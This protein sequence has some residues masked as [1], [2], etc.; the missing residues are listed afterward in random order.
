M[1]TFTANRLTLVELA[2]RTK[3]GNVTAIAEVMNQ[4]NSVL[5]DAVWGA[6]NGL[7]SHMTTKRI[8]LP[9]GSWRKINQGVAREASKTVQVS[10]VIGMLEAFSQADEVLVDISPNPGE[11]RWTEDVAFIEGLSQ[12]LSTAIFYSNTSGAP[13]KFNGFA[14]RYAN[15][16]TAN[17]SAVNNVHSCKGTGSLLSSAW[18]VQWGTDK[19]HMIYPANSPSVGIAAKDDGLQTVY[20]TNNN[21][22]K[23]YQTH[24]KMYAGLVVRDDRSVQR[25]CNIST[26]GIQTTHAWSDDKMIAAIRQMPYGGAG[27]V[28]YANRDVLT[29]MDIDSKDKANVFYGPPDAWG[30]PTMMFRGFPVKQVDALAATESAVT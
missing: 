23:V 30:R 8:A 25:V 12:T 19:V 5:D 10:E 17:V 22:F 4:V 1:A 9:S 24:F 28:I 16:T 15:L 13:E 29:A 21:P 26:S 6:A 20:D 2:K 14:T 11:F 3:D 7:T 27:A 18:I